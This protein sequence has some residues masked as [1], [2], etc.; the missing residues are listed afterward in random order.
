MT[1][2][3]HTRIAAIAIFLSLCG[4]ACTQALGIKDAEGHI[5]GLI[6][7][8]SFDRT[9]ALNW[10]KALKD[11]SYEESHPEAFQAAPAFR[12]YHGDGEP[13]PSPSSAQLI[14]HG[15]HLGGDYFL[16][17]QE[18][19]GQYPTLRLI[20]DARQVAPGVVRLGCEPDSAVL[21][22]AMHPAGDGKLCSAAVAVGELTITRAKDLGL[23]EGGSL[24]VHGSELIL[25]RIHDT[26]CGDLRG[27]LP[28]TTCP[29]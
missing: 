23:S 1:R 18:Q 21:L 13:I 14:V 29:D 24:A 22:H 26:P 8:V 12:G 16:V 28:L 4:G 9:F 2:S 15:A 6:N 27:K 17:T 7:S 10:D 25:Y 3:R 19:P 11:P 20:L 5:Y